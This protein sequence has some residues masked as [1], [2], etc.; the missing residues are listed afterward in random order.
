VERGFQTARIIIDKIFGWH[1]GFVRLLR[2]IQVEADMPAI[3]TRKLAKSH[4][5][6][7]LRMD[8]R[9]VIDMSRWPAK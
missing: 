7:V 6:V 5:F 2:S 8:V 3:T 1:R 4:P 9:F